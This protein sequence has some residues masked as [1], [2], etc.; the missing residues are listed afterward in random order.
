[1]GVKEGETYTC[2]SL[3]PREFL[4]PDQEGGTLMEH[5]KL[6]E[7]N[8]QSWESWGAKQLGFTGQGNGKLHRGKIPEVHASVPA[9]ILSRVLNTQQSTEQCVHVRT[10]PEAKQSIKGLWGDSPLK[11]TGPGKLPVSPAR[12]ESLIT[13][14]ALVQ[15]SKGSCY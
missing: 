8:T 10:L 2:P 11:L 12:L 5:D 15:F 14:G 7:L 9:R 3:Q 6:P 13:L 4:A 1:M